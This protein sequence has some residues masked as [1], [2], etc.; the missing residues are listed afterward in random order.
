M[1]DNQVV[2]NEWPL[3]RVTSAFVSDDG[4]VRKIEVKVS[5]NDTVKK[6]TRPISEVVL[7]LPKED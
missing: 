7:L 6:F 3:A 4:K 5:S 1:K 2:R